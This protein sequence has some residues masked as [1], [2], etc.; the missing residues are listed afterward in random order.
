M[1]EKMERLPL[2]EPDLLNP[3]PDHS[4]SVPASS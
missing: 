3:I 4:Y 1:T 2:S